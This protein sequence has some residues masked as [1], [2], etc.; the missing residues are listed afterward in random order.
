VRSEHMIERQGK[1]YVLFSGLLSEAHDK[2]LREIETDLLQIPSA[3]NGNVAIVKAR[4]TMQVEGELKTFTGIGDASPE[5]VS[6]NIVPHIIRQAETRSKARALRDAINVG[7]TAFEETGE[8]EEEGVQPE[9]TQDAERTP[10]GASRKAAGKLWHLV[11][12]REGA[13]EWEAEHGLIKEMSARQVSDH[14][15]ELTV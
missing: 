2:G 10:G 14:I 9:P 5:N 15:D 3:E 1:S 12:G 11:G 7:A 13:S 6:R 4:V 8:S